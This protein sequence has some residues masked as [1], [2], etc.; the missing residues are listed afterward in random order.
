M[1]YLIYWNKTDY[2]FDKITD[3][4]LFAISKIKNRSINK[5]GSDIPI[6]RDDGWRLAPEELIYA[7]K[8]DR[9]WIYLAQDDSCIQGRLTYPRMI[10]K[11]GT[12]GSPYL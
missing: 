3:A 12:L 2:F 10:R 1:R 7:V 6:L 9:K 11:D 5:K 8:Y 4:R